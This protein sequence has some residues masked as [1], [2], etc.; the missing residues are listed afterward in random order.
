MSYLPIFDTDKSSTRDKIVIL[1]SLTPGLNTKQ[2]NSLLKKQYSLSV[3]YQ[4]IHKTLKQMMTDGVLVNMEKGYFL[5]PEWIGELSHF[6]EKYNSLSV[7]KESTVKTYTISEDLQTI[8]IDNLPDAEAL[9]HKFR[10][11]Y[12]DNIAKYSEEDRVLCM[13]SP[14]L[15]VALMTP[16]AEYVFMDRLIK[17]KTKHYTLS[18]G[19]TMVDKWIAKFYNS[20]EGQPYKMKTGADCSSIIEVWIYPDKLIECFFPGKFWAA[21]N[22]L[23]H[24]I[25]RIEDINYNTLIETYNTLQGERIKFVIHKDKSLIKLGRE[26]TL[27]QFGLIKS[28]HFTNKVSTAGIDKALKNINEQRFLEMEETYRE[29]RPIFEQTVM[30]QVSP[31]NKIDQDLFVDYVISRI[32]SHA[33]IRAYLLRKFIEINNLNWKEYKDLLSYVELHLATMYCFNAGADNKTS[34]KISKSTFFKGRD[35][36][37]ETLF[38][39]VQAKYGPA[40]E[41]I[42]RD[43]DEKFYIGQVFDTLLNTI[44]YNGKSAKQAYE[45]IKKNYNY[46]DIGIEFRVI[47]SAY[48]KY[49][50]LEVPKPSYFYERTYGINAAMMENMAKM[51]T[52]LGKS[53][54]NNMTKALRIFGKC[55][56]LSNMIINDIQDFSLDLVGS[57]FTTREKESTDVYADIKNGYLTW[58]IQYGITCKDKKVQ[59]MTFKL[60]GQKKLDY[61]K[62]ESLRKLYVDTD[63]FKRALCDA[64]SYAFM[65]VSELDKIASQDNLKDVNMLKDL[66]MTTA[67]GSK[68][69]KL[70]EAKYGK[71]IRLTAKEYKTLRKLAHSKSGIPEEMIREGR[72]SSQ[73][74][75]G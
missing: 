69:I 39:S 38:K 9:F 22:T 65:G 13:Q 45:L 6:V 36:L 29:Y 41:A 58:V 8:E 14:H 47:D 57:K 74:L 55:C 43:T 49:S 34:L 51:T 28:S 56:G 30:S 75:K 15:M 64:V 53:K 40:M 1:L 19:D 26:E 21:L 50:L 20:R 16:S 24:Q 25:K 4:A 71:R 3:T 12:F 11:E 70:M 73:V 52:L 54:E 48:K 31:N 37:R 46:N 67:R 10:E 42:F 33:G 59:E 23:Y 17:T 68:Y 32:G 60:L 18:R 44:H 62:C 63:I 7:N 61:A 66:I 27:K 72:L 35:I 2:I 5:N